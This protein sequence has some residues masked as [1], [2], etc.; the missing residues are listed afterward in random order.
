MFCLVARVKGKKAMTAPVTKPTTKAPAKKKKTSKA[1][2]SKSNGKSKPA[3]KKAS[4]KADP[5]KAAKDT[6]K[7][8]PKKSEEKAKPIKSEGQAWEALMGIKASYDQ[9]ESLR[10]EKK[11][12]IGSVNDKISSVRGAILHSLDRAKGDREKGEKVDPWAVVQG[13]HKSWNKLLNLEDEK[14]EIGKEYNERIKKE[15]G[16]FR[17]RLNDIR[18]QELPF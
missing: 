3:T 4:K 2:P 18:Q 7:A 13:V 12:K 1:K 11:Q 10:E 14:S 15:E 9:A 5:G 6:A 17:K 16:N 8:D